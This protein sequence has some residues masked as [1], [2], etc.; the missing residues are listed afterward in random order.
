MK[1]RVKILS[2]SLVAM[3]VSASAISAF[4]EETNK[5]SVSLRI[6]GVDSCLLD[7]NYDVSEGST[8]ADLIKYADELSDDITV[9][10]VEDGYI[11]DVNGEAA[12][13]FGGWDGWNYCV[14]EAAPNVGVGD[15]TLSEN[16]TV[17]LYYGDYPCFIPQM[18]KSALDSEGK[19]T[20]TAQST[21]YDDNWNPIVST[22][23]LEGMTVTF[24]DSQYITDEN[25][26]ITLSD[27][28][29]TSGKHSLQVEKKNPNGAPAVLRYPENYNVTL[30]KSVF[31]DVNFDNK[32]DVND[33]TFIQLYLCGSQ[34]FSKEQQ[35]IAD[36]NKDGTVDVIDVTS[37]QNYI[38][39]FTAGI[40]E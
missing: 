4:A 12:G 26:T 13:Q 10:G 9:K 5:I 7:A 18:D 3:L 20:F 28:D 30:V 19:I 22:I 16:D 40:A 23:P 34:E 11:T 27:S 35:D 31:G 8:A 15:F 37:L 17:V 29:F 24:D 38:L 6:E 32:L 21:E 39:N 1:T 33:V 2:V 25:G 36:I 14:N